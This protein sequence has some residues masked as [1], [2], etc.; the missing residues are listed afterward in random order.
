MVT[1][2]NGNHTA[3]I[4]GAY[5]ED[6][7][8]IANETFDRETG[9]AIDLDQPAL[10]FAETL[11][12]RIETRKP[13]LTTA[14][15]MGKG[16]LTS[17]FDCTRNEAGECGPSTA[18]PEGQQVSH[19]PPDLVG[20]ATTS[21]S[22]QD[23]DCPAEPGSGSDYTLNECTM[24]AALTLLTTEDPDFT[25][26][27]LPEVDAMSHVFGA[28]S[29]QAQAAVIS[30]DQ[31]VGRLV[32]QLRASNKWQHSIVFVTA[33]HNFGDTAANLVGRI[34]LSQ[35]F[36]GAGPSPFGVVTHNGSASVYLTELTD[37]DAPLTTDQQA[38]LAELRKRALATEGITEA[39]YRRPNPND[40][41]ED[42][43]IDS[44]HPEWNLD[45]PRAG[46]LLITAAEEYGVLD[47][48]LNDD[49]LIAGQ[50]GHPTDRHIPFFVLSGGN[51]VADQEVAA[52][53]TPSEG[54][55]TL[56]LPEQAENVDIASTVGWIYGVGAPEQS[57][58]RILEEAFI[59]NPFQAQKD[60]DITE[61]LVKRLAIFIFD[62]NNS[63]TLH[64]LI[65]VTTCGTPVPAAAEDPATVANLK[66]LA[67]DGLFTRFG[68]I[69]AWPSV[70]MPNHNTVG[71]GVYPGHHGLIN[72]RFYL[73]EER[74]EEAPIDPQDPANPLYIG[75]SRYLVP[76]V[77]TLHE[78]IH[79]SFGDW[80]PTDGPS[81]TNAYT[82][83]VD[84]PS[85]RGADYATLEPSESYPV[86][87]DYIATQ[88]PSE[89]AADTTQ[90]CASEDPDG[91]GFESALDH[92]GQTQSR[93]LYEDTAR[94]PAPKYLI[95]N[96]TLTDGAGHHFGPHTTCQIAAFQDSDRRLG[97]IL[98]AMADTGYLGETLIVVTGDH[99]SENQNLEARGL[100][101]DFSED[102][103]KINIAH[104]M[105]DWHVYL[106]TLD[107]RVTPSRLKKGRNSLSL[108]VTDNDTA[109]PVAGATLV[110]KGSKEKD[111]TAT[112]DADG[113]A[114]LE[115]TPRGKVTVVISAEG[116]N[117]RAV[118][119][120]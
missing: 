95:H 98:R 47:T 48:R 33:D 91:Y 23:L 43:T 92:Q 31:E 75:T 26:I 81:E 41:G 87:S 49:A 116:F 106:L 40:G 58:G 57:R 77:E 99:G 114:T 52:S 66:A 117:R 56:V 1:E 22:D 80:T 69:S 42:F 10:N 115:F 110:V 64:C 53:G 70:T 89:G 109:A 34:D 96:F 79:R 61:P 65:E 44:V 9:A 94:H 85:S 17:L 24:G 4:T 63:I 101:S 2:T 104:V 107:A 6:S 13:W 82:A 18:N 76:E 73:R 29:P 25:F 103:N 93:R 88:N 108:T 14:L 90:A 39:L 11:F 37:A 15:V 62:Q 60:G 68:S 55:D 46:E 16:K 120:R 8:I 72:N 38:T 27:N 7:G 97:R 78:A 28:G 3:M 74:T 20:G 67:A 118:R 30:A 105:A 111:V 35:V 51:Y 19:L 83:S 113:K 36:A 50:H 102:L 32:D 100:P 86:P 12:D 5:G 112:T 21:P 59:K 54:D 119:L 71:S 84:E 45:T